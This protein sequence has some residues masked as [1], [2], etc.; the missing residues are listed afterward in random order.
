MSE[1]NFD[2][3]NNI[4]LKIEKKLKENRLLRIT[5]LSKLKTK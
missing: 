5:D 2:F 3:E 4:N 1:E